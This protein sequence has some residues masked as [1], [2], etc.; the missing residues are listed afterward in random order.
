MWS[1]CRPFSLSHNSSIHNVSDRTIDASGH[2][3]LHQQDL[4]TIDPNILASE[5][6]A[7]STCQQDNRPHELFRLSHSAHRVSVVPL[8]LVPV[9]HGPLI[10]N[11][12][13]VSRADGVHPDTMH[14]PLS[15]QR[16]LERQHARLGHVVVHLRLGVIR[17][18]AGDGAGHDDAPAGA[19]TNHLARRGLGAEERPREVDVDHAAELVGRDVDGGRRAHDARKARHDVDGPEP[20]RRVAHRRPHRRRVRHVHPGELDVRPGEVGPQGIG[21][22]RAQGPVQVE[23]DEPPRAVL[24]QPAARREPEVAC[25]ACH[26][27]VAR[28]GEALQGSGLGVFLGQGRRG[29]GERAGLAAAQGDAG[30]DASGL[31][32]GAVGVHFCFVVV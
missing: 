13:H 23:Q 10:E 31:E 30:D 12:V 14:P 15:S 17:S 25:A 26:D 9:Q 3:Y 24:E 8:R 20:P 29:P 4:P 16:V 19:L 5:V 28:D 32:L 21:R 11:S 22:R 18:V 7:R 1:R 6:R 27:G 2:E